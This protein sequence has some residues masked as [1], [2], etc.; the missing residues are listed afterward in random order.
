MLSPQSIV[1]AWDNGLK[2]AL[3]L[4]DD[5][6]D[7]Q[8]LLRPG[9]NM[10]HPA[11]ILGHL[12]IYHPIIEALLTGRQFDD[13][14]DH[15]L[16]GFRGLG[17]TDDLSVYG[18][19]ISQLERF[20]SGHETVAQALLSAT[21]EQLSRPPSLERWASAYPS[22]AF[23]LPD[24]M[25]HHESLHIGQLSMWRRAAGLSAVESPNRTP[26]AGLTD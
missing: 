3:A 4:L 10:N 16:F 9:S 26:R 17:P 24:L 20:G 7:D 13:P 8:M 25:L 5:V 2:Y 14:A 11:W 23:M 15:E 12:S 21:E 19:K 6:T 22:V 1:Y 18:P